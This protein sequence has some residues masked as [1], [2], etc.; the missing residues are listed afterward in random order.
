MGLMFIRYTRL[1]GIPI[2]CSLFFLVNVDTG[3]IPRI[4]FLAS[5]GIMI[6]IFGSVSANVT[7][8]HNTGEL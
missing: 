4:A 8:Q 7:T 3:N 5:T 2:S 1:G 6:M